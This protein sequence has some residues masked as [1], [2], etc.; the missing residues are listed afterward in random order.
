MNELKKKELTATEMESVVGGLSEFD[1][2]MNADMKA[3]IALEQND[4]LTNLSEANLFII[5]TEN[6]R[7]EI[8]QQPDRDSRRAKMFEILRRK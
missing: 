6:E 2:L 7:D 5:L 3:T 8:T 4:F 1:Y